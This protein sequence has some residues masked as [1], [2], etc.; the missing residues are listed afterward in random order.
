M[1]VGEHLLWLILVLKNNLSVL[2]IY[3]IGK[4]LF[5]LIF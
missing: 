3:G 2:L 5:E 1:K 4:A